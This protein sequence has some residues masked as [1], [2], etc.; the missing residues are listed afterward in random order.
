MPEPLDMRQL[1]AGGRS[2]DKAV[3]VALLREVVEHGRDV[4]EKPGGIHVAEEV[5]RRSLGRRHS[6]GPG[7]RL[8]GH[9]RRPSE[10]ALPEEP[11]AFTRDHYGPLAARGHHL[12]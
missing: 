9:H 6:H 7:W 3:R 1:D 11:D 5:Q 2:L 12:E 4:R 8:E 10:A